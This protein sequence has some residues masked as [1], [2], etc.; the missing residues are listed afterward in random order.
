MFTALFPSWLVCPSAAILY[1][2]YLMVF[3]ARGMA[4]LASILAQL[5]RLSW[6]N[7]RLYF[8]AGMTALG[9]GMRKYGK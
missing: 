3:L 5:N 1:Q 6:S 7:W 9:G 2:R 4:K 8:S